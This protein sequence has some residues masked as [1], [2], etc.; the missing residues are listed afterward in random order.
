M[1]QPLGL[2]RL[3]SAHER[4]PPA[5]AAVSP[6][7]KL[8]NYQKIPT[9]IK[10]RAIHLPLPISK[11]SQLDDFFCQIGCIRLPVVMAY[12]EEDQDAVTDAADLLTSNRNACLKYTLDNSSH[13]PHHPLSLPLGLEHREQRLPEG[14]TSLT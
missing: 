14:V 8:G 6:Q 7:G 3:G 11:D 2:T 1:V 4:R 13:V 9:D 12:T 10:Q 5:L